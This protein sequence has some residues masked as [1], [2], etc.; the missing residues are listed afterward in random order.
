MG[1]LTPALSAKC[2][3]ILDDLAS[4]PIAT[5]FLEPIDPDLD[6]IPSYREIVKQPSDLGTVRQKLLNNDFST[7]NDFEKSVNL[8]WDNAILFN[9]G[10]STIGAMAKRL[11]RIF[12]RRIADFQTQTHELWVSSYLKSQDT[13]CKLFR[14]QPNLLQDFN[15]SPDV[16][17]LVPDRKGAKT[18]LSTEDTAF[19][20]QAFSYMDD[21]VQ[22]SRLIHILAENE[23]SIDFSEDELQINLSALSQKTVRLLKGWLSESREG[24]LKRAASVVEISAGPPP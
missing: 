4:H 17:M 1:G 14:D 13:L 3:A 8:I 23:P 9:G 12:Q 11:K 22:L 19:F 6:G 2:L 5:I 15:L 20:A 16:E 7:I 10:S 21:P 18:L 24:S